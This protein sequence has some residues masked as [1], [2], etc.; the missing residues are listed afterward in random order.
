[1]GGE[2]APMMG[3]VC[4][5]A[6]MIVAGF[7]HASWIATGIAATVLLVGMRALRAL[8][9]QDPHWF[10]TFRRRVSVYGLAV[11]VTARSAP[12]RKYGPPCLTR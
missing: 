9:K 2:R 1:M 3:L 8:A 4:S 12:Y 6:I 7:T 5:S 10:G 11:S